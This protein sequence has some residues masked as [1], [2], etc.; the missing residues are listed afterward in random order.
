MFLSLNGITHLVNTAGI[1]SESDVVRPNELQ[2]NGLGIELLNL[3]VPYLIE[4]QSFL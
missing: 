2:L 4:Q 1:L 3:E